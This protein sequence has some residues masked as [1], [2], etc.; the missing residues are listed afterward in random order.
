[1]SIKIANLNLNE[2]N[3]VSGGGDV[4]V[5]VKTGFVTAKKLSM[6]YCVGKEL[7]V[8]LQ[9]LDAWSIVN[10]A[11]CI[12]VTTFVREA[13]VAGINKKSGEKVKWI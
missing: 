10:L 1:M 8:G 12:G 13:V 9:N 3:T 7:K 2:I 4:G 6:L 5:L 11:V